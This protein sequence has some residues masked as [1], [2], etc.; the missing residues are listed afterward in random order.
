[1]DIDNYIDQELSIELLEKMAKEIFDSIEND[2]KT[3]VEHILVPTHSIDLINV[4]FDL[5]LDGEDEPVK[6]ELTAEQKEQ[7]EQWQRRQMG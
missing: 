3:Y 7:K 2:F 5:N 1:M 4:T 6:N